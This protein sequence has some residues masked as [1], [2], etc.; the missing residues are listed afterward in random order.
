MNLKNSGF[1]KLIMMMFLFEMSLYVNL[2]QRN[3]SKIKHCRRNLIIS[4]TTLS[5]TVTVFPAYL[6]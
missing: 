3:D 5:M 4:Q 6:K 2:L 1:R